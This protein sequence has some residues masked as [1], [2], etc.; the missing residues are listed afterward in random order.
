[1]DRKQILPRLCFLI[2]VA[3]TLVGMILRTICMLTQYDAALGYF[4]AGVLPTTSSILYYIAIAITVV[5]ALL[6]PKDALG[7]EL[8]TPHRAP[9]AYV[10]GL[11]FAA[12]TV[13]SLMTSYATLFVP[14]GWLTTALTLSAL[15]A[16]TYFILSASRHGK[17]RDGLIWL[18]Y[19]PIIWGLLAIAVTYADPYVAMNSPLKTSLQMGL[20]G[21]ML[22][23]I[24]ELRYRL[25]KALPRGA[26][27]ITGI[28]MFLTCN[29]G[30]PILAAMSQIGDPLYPLCAGVLLF[31]GLYGGYMLFCYTHRPTTCPHVNAEVEEPSD[32]HPDESETG[33]DPIA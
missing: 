27:A 24:A 15:L 16:A 8:C 22:I 21:F 4:N 1:M 2:S 20:L 10:T 18:G 25:G 23:M 26:V 29:A 32:T 30:L 17:F 5:L 11:V 13:L 6:I 28:G 7:G 31:T 33:S 9:V 12:F 14:G 3:L 19:L